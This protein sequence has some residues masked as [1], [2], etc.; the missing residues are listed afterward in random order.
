MPQQIIDGIPP[1]DGGQIPKPGPGPGPEPGPNVGVGISIDVCDLVSLIGG[2]F[3]PNDPNPNTPSIKPDIWKDQKF[4]ENLF[5]WTELIDPNRINIPATAAFPKYNP[6]ELILRLG[7][8]A[9]VAP[10]VQNPMGLED[11]VL[12]FLNALRRYDLWRIELLIQTGVKLWELSVAPT[13]AQSSDKL[14]PLPAPQGPPSIGNPAKFNQLT[15]GIPELSRSLYPYILYGEHASLRHDPKRVGDKW[16]APLPAMPAKVQRSVSSQEDFELRSRLM[17]RFNPKTLTDDV[18]T[19]IQ[20]LADQFF[21]KSP[22]REM[23]LDIER[24]PMRV[25][26]DPPRGGV[27][28]GDSR[29]E[30]HA[31]TMAIES[32]TPST[33][34]L[35]TGVPPNLTDAEIAAIIYKSTWYRESIGYKAPLLEKVMIAMFDSG[36]D[37]D[38][39]AVQGKVI[40]MDPAYKYDYAGHGTHVSTIMVGNNLSSDPALSDVPPGLTPN[41]QVLSWKVTKPSPI[42]WGSKTYY[43]VDSTLYATA[44]YKLSKHS[45][46]GKALRVVNISMGGETPMSASERSDITALHL[47]GCIVIAA[48]GNHDS[49]KDTAGV[50]YPAAYDRVLSVGAYRRELDKSQEFPATVPFRWESSNVGGPFTE[51]DSAR[52][53]VDIYAPGRN[54]LAAVPKYTTLLQAKDGSFLKAKAYLTGTS[55]AAPVVSA[56][57]AVLLARDPNLDFLDLVKLLHTT[58]SESIPDGTVILKLEKLFKAGSN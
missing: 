50:L 57:A 38:H 48:A 3:H 54:I 39:P 41:G 1:T 36:I 16:A 52:G 37:V 22:A 34:P 19:E 5:D 18:A 31:L 51:H 15:Q 9:L 47:R 40:P 27:A 32:N 28:L 29:D 10:S 35:P 55:M 7:Q 49:G 11:P 30:A 44:F 33:P 26:G 20:R 46:C 13:E 58:Y 24:T 45:E 21:F 14:L 4:T 23:F 42:T 2:L 43:P 6:G 17:L 56:I 8:S 12:K 25:V 53:S